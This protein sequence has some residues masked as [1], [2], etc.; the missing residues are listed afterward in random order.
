MRRLYSALGL[1][2]M[3]EIAKTHEVIA[4]RLMSTEIGPLQRVRVL[5]R[6]GWS[7]SFC[8]KGTTL[9]TYLYRF[10]TTDNN[11]GV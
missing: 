10:S 5:V 1:I 2:W 3:M 4:G 9:L 6:T 8:M 7:S 11:Y